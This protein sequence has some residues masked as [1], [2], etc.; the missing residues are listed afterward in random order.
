[1]CS[2]AAKL[3]VQS[4]QATVLRAELAAV[5]GYRG[6]DGLVSLQPGAVVTLEVALRSST[7]RQLQQRDVQVQSIRVGARGFSIMGGDVRALSVR[8]GGRLSLDFGSSADTAQRLEEVRWLVC[9][10]PL[11]SSTHPTAANFAVPRGGGVWISKVAA[12]Q[13]RARSRL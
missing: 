12:E 10:P 1:M 5:Q 11:C 8:Y 4:A 2:T 6:L 13:P 7:L 3:D 9:S